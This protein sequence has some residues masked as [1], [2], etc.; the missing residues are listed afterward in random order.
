MPVNQNPFNRR[1]AEYGHCPPPKCV[2]LS[3]FDDLVIKILGDQGG[4]DDSLWRFVDQ[5]P[6]RTSRNIKTPS[7]NSVDN[8]AVQST[9]SPI[10]DSATN[11][12]VQNQNLNQ[13][14]IRSQGP[15][16][17]AT[18]SVC[19]RESAM[20]LD[21]FVGEEIEGHGSSNAE[22]AVRANSESLAQLVFRYWSSVMHTSAIAEWINSDDSLKNPPSSTTALDTLALLLQHHTQ[23][24]SD[25]KE[26]INVTLGKR[27]RYFLDI[28]EEDEFM[29]RNKTKSKF[30]SLRSWE[31]LFYP[32][33]GDTHDGCYRDWLLSELQER[34]KINAS[35]GKSKKRR[36]A[37]P[38]FW[39]A[40]MAPSES[41]L[42][43]ITAPPVPVAIHHPAAWSIR[44]Q[45]ENTLPLDE[46]GR[47]NVQFIHPA[48]IR[49]IPIFPQHERLLPSVKSTVM[50]SDHAL[51]TDFK[52]AKRKPGAVGAYTAHE[53]VVDI[54]NVG[55]LVV[56]DVDDFNLYASAVR[57]QLLQQEAEN[58]VRLARLQHII[59]MNEAPL[60][61]EKKRERLE[62]IVYRAVLR[63]EPTSVERVVY[64]FKPSR[65]QSATQAMIKERG[66]LYGDKEPEGVLRLDILGKVIPRRAA[67]VAMPLQHTQPR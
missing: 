45:G 10:L 22:T 37:D 21:E 12:H 33:Y 25:A 62:R 29:Q 2:S 27:G 49:T 67:E 44:T 55:S 53:P 48:N 1:I 34:K 50:K 4:V 41:T 58:F 42:A 28:W 57:Q 43:H 59:V 16:P 26:S 51:Y 35:G 66:G 32:G 9:Q 3:A 24:I 13:T 63:M 52:T 46:K 8:P 65:A 6:D 18:P 11:S 36:S 23:A 54:N 61:L 17:R 38:I 39:S 30:R 47:I 40:V 64:A 19:G 56:E 5:L 31:D 14:Q 7:K 20:S 60:A 15:S